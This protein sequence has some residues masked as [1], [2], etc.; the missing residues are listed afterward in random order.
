MGP[1]C[2]TLVSTF[3]GKE[4]VAGAPK[5]NRVELLWLVCPNN[6]LVGGAL[7]LLN[8]N[9]DD[10]DSLLSPFGWTSRVGLSS[11]RRS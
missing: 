5:V 8:E 9:R 4:L 2:V 7:A 1:F 6:V 10:L 3:G 11:I